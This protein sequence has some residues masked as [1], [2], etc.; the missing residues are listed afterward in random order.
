M[1]DEC[2]HEPMN[3]DEP[4]CDMC[5]L[6]PEIV[7]EREK[8]M[9]EKIGWYAHFVHDEPETPFH[10]NYHTHGLTH[11][12]KHPDLQACIPINFEV[13]HSIV[14]SIVK[15]IKE[16][17]KFKAGDKVLD[18]L[19]NDFPITFMESKECGRDVLRVIFPDPSGRL[20]KEDIEEP[21]DKQ[22]E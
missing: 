16:G 2:D 12:F 1:I 10:I 15:Q 9:M 4:V 5:A 13:L 6:G 21:Y 20:A 8:E 14:C 18:I 19:Q 22:Y 11:T 7:E 3:P 17:K